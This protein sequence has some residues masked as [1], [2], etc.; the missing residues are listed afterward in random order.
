[1]RKKSLSRLKQKVWRRIFGCG[2]YIATSVALGV[3]SLLWADS[4]TVFAAS[5][6]KPVFEEISPV[7]E[8][9]SG[10]DLVVSF[11]GSALIARQIQLGAPADVFISANPLWMDHLLEQ[12]VVET[13]NRFNLTSNRLALIASMPPHSR[14]DDVFGFLSTQHTS[15]IAMGLVNAVPAGQYGKTALE[16]QGLWRQLEPNIVQTDNVRAAL[17]LVAL[18]EVP[19]G[20]VYHSDAK[21][22]A[23]VHLIGVFPEESH[24]SIVYPA[25]AVGADPSAATEEFLLFLKSDITQDALQAHGFTL[26]E[27]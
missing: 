27:Q 11:A 15:S 22:S 13:K 21:S 18:G 12:G 17:A 2:R 10:H 16:N 14:Y 7:F 26:I 23:K 24:D 6:L 4:I 19:L 5:S 3:P 9:Q 1:M 20:I 25:A 8:A